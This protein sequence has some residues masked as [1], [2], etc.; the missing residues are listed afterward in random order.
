MRQCSLLIVVAFATLAATCAVD[1]AEK[2]P[3][4]NIIIFLSDDVGYGEYGFQ[5]NAEIPTPN[6]DSIARN[7]VRFTQAYN[8]ATYCSPCRAGF[9]TGRYPTRFGHEFN[10]GGAAGNRRGFGLLLEEK[11]IA[12]R[13][14]QLGYSTACVGKWHL[15][16]GPKFIATARGFDEFYGTVANTPFFN[17]PNFIDTRKSP[18]V[19]PIVDDSFYTTD[20]YAARAVDWIGKQKDKPF[21]LYLPFNAQH[22]PLQATQKYLDRFPQ[23]TDPKRK[24]F[25][26]MMSAMDDAVGAVLAQVKKMG[27]EENTLVV[28]F[29]DNG[30]PTPST[31]SKNGPLRGFKATTLEGGIRVPHCMQWK[32]KIQPGSTFERPILNLDILPTAVVAAGGTI[33]PEWK[34]DGVDLMPYLSGKNKGQLHETL[35]WRFGQQ[36]AIRKGDWKLCANRIDGVESPRLFNLRDDIGEAKDLSSEHPD[37]VKDLQAD[38]SKWSSEQMEPRWQPRARR[39]RAAG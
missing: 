2:P 21:F 39:A 20:A 34:L 37:K 16:G 12:D 24:T 6:V 38:W 5:G 13:L 25:A 33:D 1:A 15:G 36:W 19:T 31:T 17:P 23:I 32:G 3:R 26:A 9:M 28:F 11:T 27:Q 30:G 18:E 29:S 4:P 22:A 35:Y 8:A 14:K 7:G 10:E